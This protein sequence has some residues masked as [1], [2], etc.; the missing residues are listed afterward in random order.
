MKKSILIGLILLSVICQAQVK[1]DTIAIN[2]PSKLYFIAKGKMGF[3][4]IELTNNNDINGYLFQADFLLSSRLSKKYRLEYGIGFLEFYGNTLNNNRLETVKNESIIIPVNIVYNKEFSNQVSLI[5]G[6]GIYANYLV[7]ADIPGYFEENNIGF[8][9]GLG[10]QIGLNFKLT[11]NFDFRIM[12]ESQN[13]FFKIKKDI[14]E[15]K[16]KNP[17][18]FSTNLVFK[19]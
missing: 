9:L 18:L 11:D 2:K 4:Q 7:S 8:N 1:K 19:L 6:L 15:I 16:Q 5:Y 12:V 13:D 17:A 10:S 14:F 3:S